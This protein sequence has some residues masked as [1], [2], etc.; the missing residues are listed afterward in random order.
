MGWSGRLHGQEVE[1]DERRPSKA[2]LLVGVDSG[3]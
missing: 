3:G 2:N 1:T